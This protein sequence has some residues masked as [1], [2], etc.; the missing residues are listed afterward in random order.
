MSR[1]IGPGSHPL[2]PSF[3]RIKTKCSD[4]GCWRCWM[5]A[6]L[7]VKGQRNTKF[8]PIHF[9]CQQQIKI[10]Q[11]DRP[12]LWRKDF[13]FLGVILKVLC[14]QTNSKKLLLLQSSRAGSVFVLGE[15]RHCQCNPLLHPLTSALKTW[16]L[17][18]IATSLLN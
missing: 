9:S 15:M 1:F 8:I 16:A 12:A 5:P 14:P 11:V 6:D 17:F 2:Q 10:V 4:L 7:M 18:W 13:C 3:V